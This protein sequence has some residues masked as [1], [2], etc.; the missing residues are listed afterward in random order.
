[1]YLFIYIYIYIARQRCHSWTTRMCIQKWIVNVCVLK[2][3]PFLLWA[4]IFLE[5]WLHFVPFFHMWK[6]QPTYQNPHLHSPNQLTRVYLIFFP[7]LAKPKPLAFPNPGS[8]V[9]GVWPYVQRSFTQTF[10]TTS[11]TGRYRDVWWHA[12]LVPHPP[13]WLF[14]AHIKPLNSFVLGAS[15][16]HKI[17]KLIL[18]PRGKGLERER[19]SEIQLLSHVHRRQ[20]Q[21]WL[22]K[23]N[24]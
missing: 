12:P 14:I 7:V 11:D 19:E 18:R 16:K 3:M 5:M 4:E 21:C 13:Q 1:M 15:T 6:C 20:R 24:K 10:L 8:Q 22:E 2:R 17:K 23:T 9:A